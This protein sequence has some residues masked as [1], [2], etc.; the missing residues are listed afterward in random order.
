[1]KEPAQASLPVLRVTGYEVRLSPV[2]TEGVCRATWNGIMSSLRAEPP[3]GASRP[4]GGSIA[5]PPREEMDDGWQRWMHSE[6]WTS[7][8]AIRSREDNMHTGHRQDDS[9][10]KDPSSKT[11][12]AAASHLFNSLGIRG[13]NSGIAEWGLRTNGGS[14]S[15]SPP[16]S[17]YIVLGGLEGKIAGTDVSP[18]I[19]RFPW[20]GFEEVGLQTVKS[21]SGG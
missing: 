17:K 8:A 3:D 20:E 21:A 10:H 13:L 5:R 2:F 19:A 1:M 4:A 18:P 9:G 6:S 7:Q 15:G 14:S 16:E 12:R 11:P